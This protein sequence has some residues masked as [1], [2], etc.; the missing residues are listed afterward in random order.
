M[1]L[2]VGDESVVLLGLRMCLLGE[3][4]RLT[5]KEDGARNPALASVYGG[6]S[7]VRE[8]KLPCRIGEC[9]GQWTEDLCR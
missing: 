4:F 1:S 9:P 3:A 6:Y 7:D 2:F 8:K 5:G